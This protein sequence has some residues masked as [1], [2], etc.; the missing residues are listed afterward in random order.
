VIV[1]L[2]VERGDHA[3]APLFVVLLDDA[4]DRRAVVARGGLVC[5]GLFLELRERGELLGR[6]RRRRRYLLSGLRRRR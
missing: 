4:G 3:P 6:R 2:A 5:R 1:D